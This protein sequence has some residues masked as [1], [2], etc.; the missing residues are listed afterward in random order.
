MLYGDSALDALYFFRGAGATK[1]K[2]PLFCI[3]VY[4]LLQT[5]FSVLSE[6]EWPDFKNWL[7]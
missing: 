6:S 5:F 4:L 2:T 1:A 3:K 7:N